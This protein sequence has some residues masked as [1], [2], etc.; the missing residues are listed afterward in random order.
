[1][2]SHNGYAPTAGWIR[3]ELQRSLVAAASARA[4]FVGLKAYK[5]AIH[6]TQRL[7]T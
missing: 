5:A 1:M 2:Q 6:R 4:Q 7:S 3:N